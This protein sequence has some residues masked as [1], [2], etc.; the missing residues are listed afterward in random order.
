MTNFWM[1]SDE[2][3]VEAERRIE[4]ALR[5]QF[6]NLGVAKINKMAILKEALRVCIESMDA[7]DWQKKYL[8]DYLLAANIGRRSQSGIDVSGKEY[9][10]QIVGKLRK[11][12]ATAKKGKKAPFVLAAY[13]AMRIAGDH[14]VSTSS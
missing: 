3:V 10:R 7:V 13:I 12:A 8:A 14:Y 9:L 2:H 6:D 11:S 1:Y 4:A 5:P